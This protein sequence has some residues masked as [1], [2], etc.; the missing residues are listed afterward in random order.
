MTILESVLE[1][2]DELASKKLLEQCQIVNAEIA[3]IT[4]PYSKQKSVILIRS[5]I[6]R[7]TIING[8]YIDNNLLNGE[9]VRGVNISQPN[10]NSV[11]YYRRTGTFQTPMSLLEQKEIKGFD[12]SSYFLG[13]K[14]KNKFD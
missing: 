14:T 3:V 2:I 1:T 7:S 6:A 5:V 9:F 10:I 8:E 12:V 13:A 4:E 11:K